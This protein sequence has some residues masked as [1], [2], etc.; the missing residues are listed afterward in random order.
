[1]T[2]DADQKKRFLVMPTVRRCSDEGEARQRDWTLPARTSSR[3]SIRE[4]NRRN[5]TCMDKDFIEE[6]REGI[7]RGEEQS[8]G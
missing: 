7:F 6:E 8:T 3:N 4:V 1:M 5:R 2:D